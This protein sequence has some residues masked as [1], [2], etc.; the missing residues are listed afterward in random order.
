MSDTHHPPAHL[1]SFLRLQYALVATLLLAFWGAMTVA[2][3]VTFSLTAWDSRTADSSVAAPPAA[4]A[5]ATPSAALEPP[6]P[7]AV[8]DAAVY[9][10]GA[11]T[12]GDGV[13]TRYNF[14]DLVCTAG[15]MTI[16]TTGADVF[17]ELP[18]DRAL[19]RAQILQYLG[20]PAQ[21]RVAGGQLTLRA[22]AAPPATFAVANVWTRER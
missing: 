21:I 1:R 2:V 5:T 6:R 3:L 14:Y 9:V 4:V 22:G 17:A 12:I 18:C 11:T 16:V 7:P 10:S 15:V 20:Q 13:D 19:S 8:P